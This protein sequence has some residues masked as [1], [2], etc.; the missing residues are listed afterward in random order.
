M[1]A[2]GAIPLA[3]PHAALLR[4]LHATPGQTV[5][6]GA[7]LFDLVAL[8]TVWLRF[9][10]TL[11]TSTPSIDGRRLKSC[12]WAASSVR[13]GSRTRRRPADG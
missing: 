5:S 1:S 10:S 12:P 13:R 11:A 8:E 9:R 6:G 3:A 7:P 2:S 4:T